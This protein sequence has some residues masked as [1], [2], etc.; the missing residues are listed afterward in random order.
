MSLSQAARKYWTLNFGKLQQVVFVVSEV[1]YINYICSFQNYFW[2]FVFGILNFS[3]KRT[4]KLRNILNIS[5]MVCK[6]NI[7]CQYQIGSLPRSLSYQLTIENATS[8]YLSC[9]FIWQGKWHDTAENIPL[10]FL[11]R[12]HVGNVGNYR[13]WMYFG[14]KFW[15]AVNGEPSSARCLYWS[16]MKVASF[17]SEKKFY[18]KKWN[19]LAFHPGPLETPSGEG[20]PLPY[21]YNWMLKLALFP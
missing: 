3:Y 11:S 21:R 12:C 4:Y 10:W 19:D 15:H 16:R 20:S 2:L 6:K 8:Y 17:C 7:N 13:P 18:G 5:E 1:D 14:T 9:G